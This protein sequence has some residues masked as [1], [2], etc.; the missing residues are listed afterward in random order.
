M[1]LKPYKF[2]LKLTKYDKAPTDELVDE[3]ITK[4]KFILPTIEHLLAFIIK[5][6]IKRFWKYNWRQKIIRFVITL[7]FSTLV[8]FSYYYI[9]YPKVKPITIEKVKIIDKYPT[10]STMNLKNFLRQISYTESRYDVGV[11]RKG[12]QYLGLYQIGDDIRKSVG[13]SDIP[14]NI[15]LNHEE[16]QH[17]A[18][19]KSLKS[20]KTILQ[21]YIN[22]YSGTIVG[23]IL[24][25]ESGILGMAHT[26][27]G[28]VKSFLDSDGR[29]VGE[30]G[31]G[32]KCT[33]YLKLG[34]YRLNLD[35]YDENGIRWD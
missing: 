29:T 35:K 28:N 17:I 5:E 12:S 27:I 14:Y 1:I 24:V 8:Y 10:D 16:I 26:G 19:I 9:I 30:D 11:R 32:V 2:L 3:C 4:V 15:Y 34:G 20:Y 22:K 33:D 31:N 13:M 7:L 25:T 18:M 21:P 23:G 6:K